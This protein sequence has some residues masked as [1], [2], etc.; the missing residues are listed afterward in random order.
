MRLVPAASC[1]NSTRTATYPTALPAAHRLSGAPQLNEEHGGFPPLASLSYRA[2]ALPIRSYSHTPSPMAGAFKRG[3][4]RT[5]VFKRCGTGGAKQKEPTGQRNQ[6]R[7]PPPPV[8]LPQPRTTSIARWPLSCPAI[9]FNLFRCRLDRASHSREWSSHHQGDKGARV[10]GARSGGRTHFFG[11]PRG[12]S[13]A[14]A[15]AAA[16]AAA[17]CARFR[18][19]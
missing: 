2:S 19:R 14:G 15:E 11:A 7:W 16:V 6:A 5:G 10:L 18:A 4:P 13:V 3:D 17:A 8:G 9:T 12:R 1:A